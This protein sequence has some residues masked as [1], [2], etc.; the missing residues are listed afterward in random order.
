MYFE[1]KEDEKQNNNL[2]NKNNIDCFQPSLIS[3]NMAVT[4]SAVETNSTSANVS[5]RL[6]CIFYNIFWKRNFFRIMYF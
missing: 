3:K 1:A 5:T 4:S 2:N 6:Q